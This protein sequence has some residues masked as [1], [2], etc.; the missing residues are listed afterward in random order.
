MKYFLVSNNALS[1]T[2]PSQLEELKNLTLLSMEN[3]LFTGTIPA[4]L[5]QLDLLEDVALANNLLTGS[6]P[7]EIIDK[8]NLYNNFN[9]YGNELKDLIPIDGQVICTA[10]NSING[11]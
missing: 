5:G 10:P 9:V 2:I 8:I 7:P 3:A 1:G 6:V 11:E 4:F